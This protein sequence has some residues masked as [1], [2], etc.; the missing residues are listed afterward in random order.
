[1]MLAP[2]A[3]SVLRYVKIVKEKLGLSSQ[4]LGSYINVAPPKSY[5]NNNVSE[6][7]FHI[8]LSLPAPKGSGES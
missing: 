2:G 8:G 6:P 5:K 4:K 3:I 7:A 1:M